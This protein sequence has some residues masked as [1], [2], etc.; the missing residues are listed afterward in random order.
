MKVPF[1]LLSKS[2]F[3][4]AASTRFSNSIDQ[5]SFCIMTSMTS[6]DTRLAA[7]HPSAVNGPRAGDWVT[8]CPVC[9]AAIDAPSP[10]IDERRVNRRR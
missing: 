4:T 9:R 6:G 3:T 2:I 7:F 8:A 1:F 10:V 5:F